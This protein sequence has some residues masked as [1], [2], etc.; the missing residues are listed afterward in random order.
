MVILKEGDRGTR[1]KRLQSLLKKL[2]YNVGNIDGVYGSRTKNAVAKFQ[3]ERGIL[4]AGVVG[5]RTYDII[6]RYYRGF[7]TYVIKN[8]DTLYKISKE[9]N[10]PVEEIIL[11]NNIKN[12]NSLSIGTELIIP[13]KSLDVVYTDIDYTYEIMEENIKSLKRIYPFIE[14]GSIGKSVLGK[15]LYYIK[16]GNGKNKVSYNAAHQDRKS[17]V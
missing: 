13:Y 3:S 16:L 6:Q 14:I 17:V 5:D 2:G 11:I 8:G 15:N 7:F 10:I 12:P 9:L 1:V 4:P